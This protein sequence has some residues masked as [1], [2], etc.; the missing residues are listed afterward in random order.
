[1]VDILINDDNRC[2][3]WFN[4]KN[5]CYN[6]RRKGLNKET[7]NNDKKYRIKKSSIMFDNI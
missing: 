7:M 3:K 5:S 6:I 4:K 1:M 2:I